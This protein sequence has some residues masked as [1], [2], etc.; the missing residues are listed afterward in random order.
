MSV[1]GKLRLVLPG[2]ST[3]PIKTSLSKPTTEGKW[4]PPTTLHIPMDNTE[5]SLQDTAEYIFTLYDC[6]ET[7]MAGGK[8]YY[9]GETVLKAQ[10][11][12]GEMATVALALDGDEAQWK[13]QMK[14]TYKEK[15]DPVAAAVS[16][17]RVF[18]L[19]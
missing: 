10:D 1:F 4:S 2:D 5:S 7:Y 11:F 12:N 6:S 17:F 16:C 18:S 14:R 13:V 9:L 3:N 8:S 15:E 19:G